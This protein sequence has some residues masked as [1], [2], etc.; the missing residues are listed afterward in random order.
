MKTQFY[1]FDVKY[2]TTVDTPIMEFKDECMLAAKKA[3]ERN[4]N[5]L[6]LVVLMSGGIDSELVA[7]SLLLAGIP[8]KAVIGQYI[9]DTV[10]NK[11]YFNHYDIALAE[12]WCIKNKIEIIYCE[13]DV[14]Q[15]SKL[16]C[17]YAISSQCSSPQYACYMHMMKWCTEH[18]LYF[19]TGMSEIDIV[20]RDNIYYTV[21][22]QREH[23]INNFCVLQSLTGQWNFW[24]YDC[25]LTTAFLRLP[26]VKALMTAKVPCLLNFKHDCFSD[27]FLF[28]PRKKYTGFEHLQEWDGALRVPLREAMGEYDEKIYTPV[29]IFEGKL[30]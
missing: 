22:E 2:K 29:S 28:E 24:K 15:Q 17:E 18:G 4:T 5:N 26:T 10:C 23:G 16:L 14:Y 13:I 21:D 25:R 12:N 9:T 20:L 19:L 3:S 6:P 30:Q 8:F 11:T 27:A 1:P 7:T